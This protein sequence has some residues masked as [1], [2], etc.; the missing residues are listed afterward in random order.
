MSNS[1]LDVKY[2]ELTKNL[3]II[4]VALAVIIGAYVQSVDTIAHHAHY[5]V[6]ACGS[7]AG[8][9]RDFCL[10]KFPHALPLIIGRF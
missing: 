7:I 1:Q 3:G 2:D 10:L 5:W 6:S 8:L 9:F 4:I